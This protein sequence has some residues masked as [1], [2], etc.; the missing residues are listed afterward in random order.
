MRALGV[1][2]P[3]RG[4]GGPRRDG[5]ISLLEV[6]VTIALLTSVA[7]ATAIL[8]VPVARQSRIQRE[9]EVANLAARRVLE[10]FQA[11]PFSDLVADFPDGSVQTIP[12]LPSGTITISYADPAADPLV[13]T[14]NLTWESPELGTMQR[15]FNAV[16]TE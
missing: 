2:R 11:T 16:R 10:Q 9:T 8:L 14:A 13:L 15:T 7:L 6:A 12:D 1:R 3:G 4:G 5:G